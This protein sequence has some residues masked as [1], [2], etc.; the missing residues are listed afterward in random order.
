MLG[1]LWK[2]MHDYGISRKNGYTE[3]SLWIK[4]SLPKYAEFYVVKFVYKLDFG[5][6]K[7]PKRFLDTS[8]N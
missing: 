5:D 1:V 3:N 4:F 2:K 7:L 8:Y 6:I